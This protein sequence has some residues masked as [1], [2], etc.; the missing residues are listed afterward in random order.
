[1]AT[2]GRVYCPYIYVECRKRKFS[3]HDAADVVQDV[4]VTLI[5]SLSQFRKEGPHHRFRGWLHSV[6]RT[7]IADHVTNVVR[8]TGNAESVPASEFDEKLTSRASHQDSGEPN[9]REKSLF[10]HYVRIIETE[11]EPR[12]WQAFWK[13]VVDERS[14]ADVAELL[15]LPRN[16]VRKYRSRVLKRLRDEFGED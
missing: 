11:F 9:L 2:T 14:V 1:M 4:F 5:K 3:R 12:T 7:R 6:I 10:D 16:T 15:E 13:V 8:Q